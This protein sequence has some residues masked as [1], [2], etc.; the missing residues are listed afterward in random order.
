MADTNPKAAIDPKAKK[1]VDAIAAY[2]RKFKPWETRAGKIVKRYRDYD[3]KADSSTDSTS[4][5]NILWSNVQVLLPATFSRVPKPDV[6]RRFNDSDPVGRVACLLLERALSYE[7]EHYPDYRAAMEGCVLDRFLGGRGVS[8]VRYEPHIISVP[9]QID[10][11][12]QVT[13]DADKA[14]PEQDEQAAATEEIEYECAPVDYVHW[15]EFG[16]V[17][18]RTWEEVPAVWR[19]VYMDKAALVKRFGEKIAATIPLDTRPDQNGDNRKITAGAGSSAEGA[20]AAIYEIWDKATST[21]VWM[22]KTTQQIVDERA[23]PLKL[24]GFF[25]CPRPLYA[26]MTNCTLVPVPDFKLYQDQAN[27]LTKLQAKI[28]GLI[29]QLK[30]MG[31]YS[32][33]VPELARLFKEGG[34]GTLIPVSDWTAFSEK[35]GLKGSIDIVDLAPIVSAL[36]VAYSTVEQVKNQIYELMGISDI[37]R[38]ASDPTETYGAQKLKGQYGNMRLRNNQD[39]VVRFATEILQIKA[40]IICQHFQPSTIARIACVE[41]LTP[42]DQ[43]MVPQA[44]ELLLGPRAMDPAA[45]TDQGPLSSFRVEVSSDSMIQMDEAQEKADRSLF[46]DAVGTYMEKSLPIIQQSPQMAPLLVG[47]LKFGITGF[48]VGRTVEGMIDAALDKMTKEAQQPKEPPPDPEMQKVQAQMQLE[49][50]K[51]A[52]AQTLEQQRMQTDAQLA[53]HEQQVQAEQNA[54]QQQL[55]AQR[56]AQQAQIDAQLEQQRMAFEARMADAEAASAERL[57]Q[58]RL[59]LE[60][61]MNARDNAVKVHIAELQHQAAKY[62][63]DQ[64]PALQQDWEE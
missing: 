57:E 23:D 28:D 27:Q 58:Q 20:Q 52:N 56:D 59:A 8:W 49:D 47:L 2:E 55:E 38:G 45:D 54:H 11:G 26:T 41:Q 31:V 22:A 3:E 35:M 12:V 15:K 37:V 34:N 63:A 43:Q 1:W 36:E 13:E 6:S 7:I 44:M 17:V 10:G 39:K 14:D 16:H 18:A 5:F 46:L 9:G 42:E 33:A 4:A 50:K 53:S 64:K 24:D 21:A 25:P 48:K 29:D 32:S 51:L 61:Q 19:L 40:Q 60:A 30:V 62:A